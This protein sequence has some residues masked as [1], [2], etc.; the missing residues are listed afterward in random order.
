MASSSA[1]GSRLVARVVSILVD[2]G[3]EV[4]RLKAR[5]LG[6]NRL[7]ED[8]KVPIDDNNLVATL[9]E[10]DSGMSND[11]VEPALPMATSAMVLK[12]RSKIGSTL[13]DLGEVN[14]Y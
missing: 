13:V 1:A 5:Q 7:I 12:L 4:G 2:R 9:T 8:D 11:T 14:N 6:H 10:E 3:V